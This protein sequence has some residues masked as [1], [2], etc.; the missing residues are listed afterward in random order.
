MMKLARIAT[1]IN[2]IYQ[3]FLYINN[4]QL[5][6]QKPPCSHSRV[7]HGFAKASHT[8]GKDHHCQKRRLWARQRNL[9]IDAA[10]CQE[11]GM[12]WNSIGTIPMEQF[13]KPIVDWL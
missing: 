2:N 12:L 10:T 5:D 4:I 6:Y 3:Y 11:K 13:G 1:S 9:G 8:K 7:S